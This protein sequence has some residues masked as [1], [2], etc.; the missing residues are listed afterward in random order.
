MFKSGIYCIYNAISQKVYIGSAVNIKQR[1]RQ[2][3]SYL[4]RNIHCNQYLQL[5]WNKYG[6]ENFQFITIEYISHISQLIERE[7]YYLNLIKPYNKNIGYNQNP[8]AGSCLGNKQSKETIEKRVSK[9]RGRKA[10]KETRLKI[11]IA[12]KGNKNSFGVK[13]IRS[14]E[15]RESHAAK[16]RGRKASEETKAKMR[17]KPRLRNF[18]GQYMR[19]EP[20]GPAGQ[21]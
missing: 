4:R 21:Q 6:E 12:L 2:H 8:I 15:W 16:L 20:N 13:Q 5:A 9:F 19:V 18:Y 11:S 10:S 3:K 17:L 14:K 1:W 7:Q